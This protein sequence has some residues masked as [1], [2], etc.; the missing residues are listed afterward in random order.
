MPYLL[1]SNEIFYEPSKPFSHRLYEHLISQYNEYYTKYKEFPSV[2]SFAREQHI[3]RTTA[4]KVQEFVNGRITSFHSPKNKQ[5]NN[6]KI[7]YGKKSFTEEEE[8]FL[9]YIYEKN[10]KA[11]LVEYRNM[12]FM[13]V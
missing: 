13:Y 3:S 2:R 4:K 12:L 9:I 8:S 11:P 1:T 10:K 5:N 6:R 7:D